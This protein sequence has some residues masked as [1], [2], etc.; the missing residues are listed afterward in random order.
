VELWLRL[1]SNFRYLPGLVLLTASGAKSDFLPSGTRNLFA[2]PGDAFEHNT[3]S[4]NFLNDRKPS[5]A[6]SSRSTR[7]YFLALRKE[8]NGI[9]IKSKNLV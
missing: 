8:I 2:M 3:D 5:C 1:S 6:D 9:G 7:I 4:D